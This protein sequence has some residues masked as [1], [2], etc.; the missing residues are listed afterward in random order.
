MVRERL[1]AIFRVEAREH[2]QEMV[3]PLLALQRGEDAAQTKQAVERLFRAFHTLKGAARSVGMEAVEA[4][5][6]AAE[7]V[8]SRLV[9]DDLP[10]TPPLLDLLQDAVAHLA[11]SLAGSP[12]PAV[13]Q[14]LVSRLEAAASGL[15]GGSDAP[16]SPR[17]L[18]HPVVP[19]VTATG[20]V[21]IATAL[22]E[23]ISSRAE[24]L[25]AAKLTA[26]ARVQQA[27][28]LVDVIG[29]RHRS[30]GET[31]DDLPAIET[32]ARMLWAS[33]QQDA[34]A[35]GRAV[36]ALQQELRNLRMAPASTLVDFLPIMVH[37]LAQ[38]QNKAVDWSV[39][40][41]DLIVDRQVLEIVKD[42]LIHLVRNA[43]DHGIEAPSV[44]AAAG[45]PPRGRLNLAL[46]AR[47][48]GQIEIRLADDGAGVDLDQVR[49]AAVRARLL[50]PDAAD[51]LDDA[52]VLELVFRSGFS[53]SSI[54]TRVSGRGLGMAIVRERVEG[55]G[56][57]VKLES[58]PKRGTTVTLVLPATITTFHGLLVR[59]GGQRFLIPLDAVERTGRVQPEQIQRVEGQ[60]HLAR[61]GAFLPCCRLGAV[62][63]LEVDAD[64]PESE[65]PRSYVIVRTDT[66]RVALLV[67]T[68]EGTAEAL[69]KELTAPLVRVRNVASAGLLGSGAIVMILRAADLVQGEP[70]ARRPVASRE[71]A[72]RRP[73]VILVVDDSITTRTLEKNI[74]EMAGFA[75]QVAA[76]GA[77]AWDLLM[78][79]P[80]DLVVSDVDMPR[81]DGFVLTERLRAHPRTRD[82]PIVLVSALES[83]EEKEKGIRLGANA[84]LV[85]SSFADSHLLEIVR[86]LI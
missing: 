27:A 82:V 53:T 18:P 83:R 65:A 74:L 67:D 43:I 58:Q 68:I 12:D 41:A 39:Q 2:L 81:M 49:A 6:Q 26:A 72:S 35:I 17:A 7:G 47:E 14:A 75:V 4:P 50:T 73:A 66:H 54:I 28:A 5:C 45:K 69:V 16:A 31:S 46:A 84:Y 23:A 25:V 20:T 1:L 9:R 61:N 30:G 86:R 11:R 21:R 63:D 79:D 38:D 48:G 34:Q 33:L 8:M 78:N 59:E 56:G 57:T 64:P 37:D 44:R 22:L 42:P 60:A 85:K 51:A 62:L 70:A 36:D 10:L 24:D 71:A 32:A 29:S 80:Y 3:T 40:G 52:Q 15:E 76:D 13:S 77:E 19:D 55:L